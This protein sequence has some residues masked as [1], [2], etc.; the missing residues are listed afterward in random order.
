MIYILAR[1][2]IG[3]IRDLR[4]K[5]AHARYASIKKIDMVYHPEC[6]KRL[7]IGII[8]TFKEAYES[9]RLLADLRRQKRHGNK[10]GFF[11]NLHPSYSFFRNYQQLRF[12][13]NT[14]D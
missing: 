6:T 9:H 5:Y 14:V 3:D 8:R 4:K 2:A 12:V 11:I 7:I 1:K 13:K 10:Q